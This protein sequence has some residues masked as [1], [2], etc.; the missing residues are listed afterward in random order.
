MEEVRRI[1][2]LLLHSNGLKIRDIAKELDLDKYYVADI[3]FSTDNI[4]FWYQDSSSLW[5]AKEGA[6]EIEEP[7]ETKEPLITSIE[8]PQKFNISRFLEEDLSDSLRS[9]LHQISKYRTY[10]NDEMIELFKRYRNGDKNAFDLIIMSQQRLVANIA[11]LYCRKGAP[12]EDI[13][14]EGNVG[15]VK[16]AERFDY[17]Q[18]RSFSNYAKSWILQSISF[19]MTSMPYMIRLPLNQMSLYRKVRN[20]KDHYEQENGFAP[21]INDIEINESSDLERIKYLDE[22]PYNLK[23]LM[24][25]S[26]NM[27]TF[28]SRTNAIEDYINK[29]EG[30]FTVKKLLSRL[31]KRERQLLQMFYGI[32]RKEESLASIGE[33]FGL[34][35]ERARQIKDKTVKRLRDIL[36]NGNG[37]DDKFFLIQDEVEDDMPDNASK[38]S[39]L[40][41]NKRKHK[42]KY[43]DSVTNLSIQNELKHITE[44]KESEETPHDVNIIDNIKVGDNIFYNK[45]YCTIRKIIRNGKFSKLV[46]EYAN[47]V[48]DV[49]SYNKSKCEQISNIPQ[50]NQHNH[51]NEKE[52]SSNYVA[53]EAMVGD[54][55]KYDSE[56]CT[57]LA[58]KTMQNTLRIIVKYEDGTIDN[59]HNDMNRYI[60]VSHR[61]VFNDTRDNHSK[62]ERSKQSKFQLSTPLSELV[63]L[64]ILTEKQLHQCRK[65]GLV[66]IGDV[67]QIIEKYQ[68]TPYS[69][70]FTKYTLDMWF[71]IIRLIKK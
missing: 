63:N 52:N 1:Y 38:S 42:E 15:L 21:S 26:D 47:G 29:N 60:I 28:E 70:R 66:T 65:K 68:L 10:S 46:I 37:K 4:P 23:S 56:I 2:I 34:T 27:D 30:Q 71:N 19:A 36:Y 16:A 50:F 12:L 14:Q 49:V 39:N 40:P 8:I 61:N 44:R 22:L 51:L 55:I 9:Y 69:N 32:N 11:L 43:A 45:K 25:L 48:I 17:T 57:V 64:N 41:I 54:I 58:K 35:R 62:A 33:Y 59:L 13:I 3:L 53:K 31:Q 67:K 5:F 7:K 24:H 6:T 18:Y 20:F